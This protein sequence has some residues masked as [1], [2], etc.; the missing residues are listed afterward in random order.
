MRRKD[1]DPGRQRRLRKGLYILPSLFTAVNIAAGYYAISQAIQAANNQGDPRHYD[2]AA[3]AIGF[4]IVFDGLDGRV[5]RMTNTTSDFGRELDSLADVITF[6]M[7]PAIL[8]WLWGFHAM[9]MANTVL[10]GK[11]MRFGAVVTFLFLAAG[12]CRLARFNIQLNPQP[13]NPGRPGKKYFVGMPIPGGAGVIASVVHFAHGYPIASWWMALI[14]AFFVLTLGFLMVSRWRFPSF[15]GVDFR[16]RHSARLI[17][18]LC[19][20][21][22]MIILFSDWTLFVIS[23]TYMFWG[24][25][26]RLF[27]GFRRGSQMPPPSPD[28]VVHAD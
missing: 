16:Q 27:Y 2:L 6:G 17:V 5:A 7:A 11:L 12:A 13:S 22:A 10:Q 15:K 21:V 20:L 24:I 8:A 3:L 1:D 18:V 4:A 23:I 28:Q 14:W 9:A 26:S 19:A 25:F